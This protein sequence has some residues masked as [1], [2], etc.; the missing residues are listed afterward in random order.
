MVGKYF[1][2]LSLQYRNYMKEESKALKKK[3]NQSET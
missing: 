3:M 2:F 1:H